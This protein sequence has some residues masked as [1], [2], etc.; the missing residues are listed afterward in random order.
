MSDN[1]KKNQPLKYQTLF[2]VLTM[3][4]LLTFIILT[5]TSY[6]NKIEL[7][8][9][10]WSFTLLEQELKTD[11]QALFDLYID[12]KI[13]QK[14]IKEIVNYVKVKYPNYPKYLINYRLN[15]KL[16]ASSLFDTTLHIKFY[17]NTEEESTDNVNNLNLSQ[18]I[19]SFKDLP[20]YKINT[21]TYIKPRVNIVEDGK[22]QVSGKTNLP[23]GTSFDISIDR[24]I[25][26]L[27]HR[28]QTIVVNNNEFAS[29]I[30]T[31]E[32]EALIPLEYELSLNIASYK[33]SVEEPS[34]SN[35][36]NNLKYEQKFTVPKGSNPNIINNNLKSYLKE[37]SRLY[38]E[39][40]SFKN[41]S[42]FKTW[43]FSA[44]GPYAKWH[45]DVENLEE[46][47]IVQSLGY[48]GFLCSTISL[49]LLGLH[50]IQEDSSNEWSEYTE[51]E[52]VQE[53]QKARKY[54]NSL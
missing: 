41:T 11:Q 40:Q 2:A 20:E 36:N 52:L 37:Y 43:G 30:F 12:R 9:K 46:Y 19:T 15:N 34:T 45:S 14:D 24:W 17:K 10:N 27:Y 21:K 5:A 47:P 22:V 16:W 23:D 39:F 33:I 18:T 53:I 50:Y 3:V 1:E 31:D 35:V 42:S 38:N 13:T 4:V 28:Q 48:R 6:L 7:E 26:P 25:E 49:K 51:K 54:L 8:K 44:S 29:N 32:E